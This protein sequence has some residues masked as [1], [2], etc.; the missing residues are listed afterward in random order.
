MAE[1]VLTDSTDAALVLIREL[2]EQN[3]RLFLA[4]DSLAMACRCWV[5]MPPLAEATVC[6]AEALIA[7][8][9]GGVR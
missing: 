2:E 8:L 7:K 4:L 6:E 5:D 9:R 1:P 3:L